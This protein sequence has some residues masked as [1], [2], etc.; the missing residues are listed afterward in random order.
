LYPSKKEVTLEECGVVVGGSWLVV[1]EQEEQVVKL[2]KV[3]G[4]VVG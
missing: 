2:R 4:G 1:E 3:R